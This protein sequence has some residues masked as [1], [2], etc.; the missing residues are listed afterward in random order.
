MSTSNG[1]FTHLLGCYGGPCPGTEGGRLKT[2]NYPAPYPARQ[3]IKYEL[4][5]NYGARIRLKF[6]SFDLEQSAM[7]QYDSV[8]IIDSDGVEM[9]PYC[10][11]S[12]PP[13]FTSLTNKLTL[14]FT[15]DVAMQAGGFEA[16]WTKVPMSA[17]SKTI[18]SPNY[19]SNYPACYA[20][21]VD[22]FQGKRGSKVKIDIAKFDL[23]NDFVL[24]F[25]GAP[26]YTDVQNLFGTTPGCPTTKRKSPKKNKKQLKKNADQMLKKI[27]QNQI[28]FGF[29]FIAI[30]APGPV[31]GTAI[32]ALFPYPPLNPPV[33]TSLT[34]RTNTIT[35]WMLTDGFG[36]DSGFEFKLTEL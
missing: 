30:L 10:G 15:S 31:P 24:V 16:E 18:T 27:K 7:C 33:V 14:E 21:R 8:K 17:N 11:T 4:E 28:V 13:T 12:S 19:P 9:G 22:V 1:L 32:N 3:S 36:E 23:L 20:D 34:S 29:E 5:T 35:V 26:S 25:E 2:P 6:N